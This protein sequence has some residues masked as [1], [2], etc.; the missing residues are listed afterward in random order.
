[1]RDAQQS[2]HRRLPFSQVN[3]LEGAGGTGKS[4]QAVDL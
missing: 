3:H 4:E 1:L 2:L